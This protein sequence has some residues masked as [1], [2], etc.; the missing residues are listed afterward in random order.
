MHLLVRNAKKMTRVGFE[1]T[2]SYEDENPVYRKAVTLESHAI[3][4]SAILP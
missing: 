1:P 3:D 2:P 4:R